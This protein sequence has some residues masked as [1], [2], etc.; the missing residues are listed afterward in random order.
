MQ[1]RVP[2]EAQEGL[3]ELTTRADL[4]AVDPSQLKAAG[5]SPCPKSR[6][7]LAP[8]LPAAVADADLLPHKPTARQKRRRR[9]VS[10]VGFFEQSAQDPLTYAARVS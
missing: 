9:G 8:K 4:R 6:R 3:R 2:S 10:A 5:G 1:L 7:A